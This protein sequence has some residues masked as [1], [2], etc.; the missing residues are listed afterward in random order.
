MLT[1]TLDDESEKWKRLEGL[2]EVVIIVDWKKIT[3]FVGVSDDK[4]TVQTEI[5]KENN[6]FRCAIL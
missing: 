2:L 1:F 6:E 3:L 5:R 4:L